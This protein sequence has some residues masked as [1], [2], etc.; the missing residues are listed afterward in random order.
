MYQT[1]TKKPIELIKAL[2]ALT[3]A[4]YKETDRT[5][6]GAV[7]PDSSSW[8]ARVWFSKFFFLDYTPPSKP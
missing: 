8:L 4:F 3:A 5:H 1:F 2:S 7:C 6:K